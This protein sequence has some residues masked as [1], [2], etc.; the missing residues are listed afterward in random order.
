MASSS[1][2]QIETWLGTLEIKGKVADIG[3]LFWPA[4]GRTKI[5]NVPRYDIF[6]VVKSRRG[7]HTN[8]IWDFNR[9][10]D[11]EEVGQYDV[12]FCL[13]VTDHFWDP[14]TAFRNIRDLLREGGMLY[15]S[16]NFLFPHHTGFDCI[17]LTSTGL[18]KVLTE[19][20]FEVVEIR[21]RTAAKPA[22]LEEAMRAESKVYR[23]PGAIGYMLTAK[24]L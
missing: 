14:V 18:Q 23:N 20:G 17:R 10:R 7:V 15:V 11:W 8:V 16:S 24:R 13:E 5:W 9:Q 19:T 6:D 1:R 3:G 22:I 12:A 2:R 4:K 21:P